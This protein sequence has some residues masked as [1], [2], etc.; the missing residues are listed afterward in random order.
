MTTLA[1]LVGYG[2]LC[3]WG[4]IAFLFCYLWLE[5]RVS[6]WLAG[7]RSRVSVT[8]RDAPVSHHASRHEE[9]AGR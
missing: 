1:L 6:R 5:H 2:V 7:L 8:L 4:G 9:P 3:F